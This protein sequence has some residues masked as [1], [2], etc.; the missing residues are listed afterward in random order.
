MT[1]Q[2]RDILIF[3]EKEHILNALFLDTYLDDNTR[4]KNTSHRGMTSF[5]RGHVATFTI[6]NDELHIQ[7]LDTLGNVGRFHFASILKESFTDSKKCHWFSGLLRI[8]EHKGYFDEE[9]E[10]LKKLTHINS[11]TK[12]LQN[13]MV[14][15]KQVNT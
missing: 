10:N 6:K 13:M 9:K 11:Y 8:D 1:K 15:T 3:E 4:L 12:G 5:R 14:I 2:I 7:K